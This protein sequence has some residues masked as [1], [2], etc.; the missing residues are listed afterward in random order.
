MN[1]ATGTIQCADQKTF[2]AQFNIHGIVWT[3]TGNFTGTSVQKFTGSNVTLAY[4]DTA[5]LTGTR[6]FSGE[7][8]TNVNFTIGGPSDTPDIVTIR[9][10]L[11]NPIEGTSVSGSGTW[12]HA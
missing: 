10:R 4:G 2:I 6:I 1:A 9:G 8:G 11:D 12:S 3:F 7:V 5:W